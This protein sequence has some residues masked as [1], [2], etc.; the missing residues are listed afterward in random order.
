ML[1][2]NLWEIS[3]EGR[4][5]LIKR[6]TK[7]YGKVFGY[8]EGI[9]PVLEVADPDMVREILMKQFDNFEQRTSMFDNSRDLYVGMGEATGDRWKRIRKISNIISMCNISFCSQ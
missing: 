1:F 2:G 6:W 5:S 4:Y 7:K 8:Y 3:T 9:Q